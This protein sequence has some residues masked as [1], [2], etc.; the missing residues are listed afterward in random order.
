MESLKS[1]QTDYERLEKL[2]NEL[3]KT[4]IDNYKVGNYC[5]ALDETKNWCVGEVVDRQNDQIKVHFEGWSSKHDIP[6]LLG[7][8]KKTDHFRKFTKGYSGQK[9]TAYRTLNFQKEDFL[10]FKELVQ[11]IKANIQ[12]LLSISSSNEEKNNS[13]RFILDNALDITQILRGKAFFQ[14]DFFMTN[15]F[16]NYNVKE[17]V[18]ELVD[19]IYEYLDIIYSYLVFYKENIKYTEINKKFPDLFLVD[20]NCA[21]ISSLYEVL[22][23]L[24]RIFGRDERVNYFYKVK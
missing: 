6:V 19:I 7:K 24:K 3:K 4:N 5:D 13:V 8:F 15:P 17:M 12:N 22:F 16:N 21:I 9:M 11:D 10:A 1:S 2:A 18:G 20:K 14:L 23:T